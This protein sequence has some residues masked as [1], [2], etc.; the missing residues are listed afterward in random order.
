MR[1]ATTV[2]PVTIS[3]EVITSNYVKVKAAFLHTALMWPGVTGADKTLN[4]TKIKGLKMC[5]V[6]DQLMLKAKDKICAIPMT[7]VATW[8]PEDDFHHIFD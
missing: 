8:E 4:V 2:A 6:G 3:D 5:K 7:N 1:K